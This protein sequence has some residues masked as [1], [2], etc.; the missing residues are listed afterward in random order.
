MTEQN[1][2]Y[3]MTPTEWFDQF[4]PADGWPEGGRWCARH[5]APC[6]CLGANGIGAAMDL[7]HIFVNEIATDVK[8]SDDMN[9]QMATAGH[10][11]CALG[12]ERM[13]ELWGKWPPVLD[14]E[15]DRERDH[16]IRQL[17]DVRGDSG[18]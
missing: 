4:P 12:D 17:P 10:I 14:E 11:C 8:T 13:Y 9:A 18:G 3:Q 2:A 5:W 7:L 1:D 16:G 6:P 15:A